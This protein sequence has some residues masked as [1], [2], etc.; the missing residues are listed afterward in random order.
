MGARQASFDARDCAGRALL[1]VLRTCEGRRVRGASIEP[2]RGQRTTDI[3][4][5][6]CEGHEDYEKERK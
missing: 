1:K 6:C 2:P 3:D 4:C 5:Q